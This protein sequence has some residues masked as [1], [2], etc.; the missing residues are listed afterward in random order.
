MYS[1]IES[2]KQNGL[3]PNACLTKLEIYSGVLDFVYADMVT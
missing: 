2:V 1:L 3:N